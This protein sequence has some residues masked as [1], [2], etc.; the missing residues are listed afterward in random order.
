MSQLWQHPFVSVWK[1]FGGTIEKKG[2]V[3]EQ[4]DREIGKRVF[5]ITGFVSSNNYIQ[6][7]PISHVTLQS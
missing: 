2:E 3:N 1:N 5:R 6:V 4:L 7:G